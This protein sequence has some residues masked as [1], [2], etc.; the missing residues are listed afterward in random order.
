MR[1]V[2]VTY[3]HVCFARKV[4]GLLRTMAADKLL[5]SLPALQHLLDT[6]V[7]FDVSTVSCQCH[8]CCNWGLLQ[9]IGRLL[10]GYLSHGD[11]VN[12]NLSFVAGFSKRVNKWRR[13]CSFHAAF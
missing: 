12:F 13:Q 1:Y 6:L 11:G 7:E 10:M 9:H 5:K 4:D 8:D 2:A 3:A